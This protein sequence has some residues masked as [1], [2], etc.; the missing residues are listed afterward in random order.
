M[1]HATPR[2]LAPLPLAHMPVPRFV[3]ANGI[4]LCVY[5]AG[6][7][8]SRVPPV[9][10]LHGFP[11]LAFSWRA[12]IRDLAAAGIR[13]IA[14]DL[15]GYGQSDRP[16]AIESY[17]MATLTGDVVGLL[18]ALAIERAIICGHD[19]GGLIGWQFPLIYPARTAGVI[20]LN[21]P[22]L[23]R[24]P[25]D[26]IMA[27]RAIYGEDMYI[28]FFQTP[29][30]PESLFDADTARTMR[31]FMRRTRLSIAEFNALP[32]ERRNL[33]LQKSFQAFESKDDPTEIFGLKSFLSE[34]ELAIYASS[35]AQSGFRGPVNFY[36]NL[37]RNWQASSGFPTRIDVPALMVMADRDVVLQPRFADGMEANIADLTKVLITDCGHWT[38]QEKPA[39]TSAA[40]VAFLR[41]KFGAPHA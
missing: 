16:S 18:D 27:F 22:F 21:T 11:E 35:F 41:A 38:Q 26:P 39:E 14:P 12:Q 2:T 4:R 8:D 36:R 7:K 37:S 34:D 6:P 25:V 5:E 24:A 15:R 17:D 28:V 10:L 19:W 33:A 20:G 32:A 23:P 31:F 3:E 29:D 30:I 1:T 40:M 13:V 9:V